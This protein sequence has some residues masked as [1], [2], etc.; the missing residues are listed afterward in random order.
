MKLL[1]KPSLIPNGSK[2]TKKTGNKEYILRDRITVYNEKGLPT[3]IPY[4]MGVKFMVDNSGNI[5][6]VSDNVELVWLVDE[7]ELRDYLCC[8]N[9][10]SQ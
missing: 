10:V 9:S 2:V 6:T 8:D 4:S 3:T 7:E 1:I 5:Q